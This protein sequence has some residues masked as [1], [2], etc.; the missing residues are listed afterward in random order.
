MNRGRQ[1]VATRRKG[2]VPA[3]RTVEWKVSGD[4]GAGGRDVRRELPAIHRLKEL[5]LGDRIDPL[6]RLFQ[7]VLSA[8]AQRTLR[9]GSGN[10]EE[11]RCLHAQLRDR[12]YRRSG[13][14]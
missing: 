13:T 8:Q 9:H 3:R 5:L 12:L 2:E 10:P 14:G 6:P 1:R 7:G 4:F 11:R